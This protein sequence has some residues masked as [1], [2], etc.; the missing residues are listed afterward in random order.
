MFLQ[1]LYESASK[2]T[3]LAVLNCIALVL[4][5]I[6]VTFAKRHSSTV[7]YQQTNDK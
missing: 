2:L 1:I 3:I 6:L 4:F 7:F 5:A